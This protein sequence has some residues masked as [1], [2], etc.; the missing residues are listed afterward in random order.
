M[1]DESEGQKWDTD[2][3]SICGLCLERCEYCREYCYYCCRFYCSK[4]D[5]IRHYVDSTGTYKDHWI[6]TDCANSIITEFL[7]EH[8]SCPTTQN[9][10]ISKK[11]KLV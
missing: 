6:C 1:E 8:M 10:L 9:L 5:H 4:V 7:Q 3:N 2:P 11:R